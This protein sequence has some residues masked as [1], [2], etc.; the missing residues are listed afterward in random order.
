MKTR[1][2]ECVL[3]GNI[4]V[5]GNVVSHTCWDNFDLNEETPSGAGTTHSTHGI[6]IQELAVNCDVDV[7]KSAQPVESKRRSFK[8]VPAHFE[9]L[10]SSRK[11]EPCIVAKSSAAADDTYSSFWCDRGLMWVVA[12]ALFNSQGTVPD[13]SGWLSKT[14]VEECR[15]KQ[16]NIGYLLPIMQPI[17]KVATIQQCLL[18]SMEIS[19]KLKQRYTF[20][21]FDLAA[22]KIAYDVIW[23]NPHRYENVI[24]H[25]GAFHIICCYL[26]ALGRM[27][28]GSGFEEV[29]IE[30]G[31]C[32]SGSMEQVING[33]HYNRAVRVHQVMMIAV[34]QLLLEH[35]VQCTGFD[36]SLA[37]ELQALADSPTSET[38]LDAA[39]SETCREFI[40]KFRAFADSAR[41]GALGSTCQFWIQYQTCVWTLLSFLKAIKENDIPAY[42][43]LLR[44]MCP[45]ISAADRLHYARYLPMYY[46]QLS[47]LMSD[48]PEAYDLLKA[49][50][51]TVSRSSVPACCNAIDQTIEQTINRSAK[52]S[53]GII[54]FSRNVNAYYRWCLTRHKRA[55]FVEATK[56]RVGMSYNSAEVNSSCRNAELKHIQKDVRKVCEAFHNF[57]NP[58]TC[59]SSEAD[60]QLFCLSTGQPA[61]E[62]ISDSL[63]SYTARGEAATQV[64]IND[65][66]I[67]KSTKF[68]GTMKK[69]RLKTFADMSVHKVVKS[70]TQKSL[71]VIAERNL[72]GQLLLLCQSHKISF[73]KLFKYPLAPVP[74]SLATADGSM[75]KTDKAQL[76][77]VLCTEGFET[78][79]E[80]C[81]YVVDG[82]ALLYTILSVPATVGDFA[83]TVFNCLPKATVVHFVTD[84]Y[85][86]HSVKEIERQ[87]RGA[88]ATYLIGGP[89]TKMPRDF[90]SFMKNSDNKRQLLKFILCEW[91]Q[92]EYAGK[93]FGR[94]VLFVSED[95]CV[96]LRRVDG[97]SITV[98]EIAALHSTQEEADTRIVFHCIYAAEHHMSETT[99]SIVVKSPDTD[100]FV[101]LLSHATKIDASIIFE[102]G[103][104]N[105]HRLISVNKIAKA[106]GNNLAEAL[107]ALHAFTVRVPLCRNG[108]TAAD[109]IEK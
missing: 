10:P 79:P 103:T 12:H 98:T 53:G 105:N 83:R 97:T 109:D 102:T 91:C 90:A 85:M 45:L 6:V 94:T 65:R 84:S 33:K 14:A 89:S 72:L 108:I 3:P 60:H 88:S 21:T 27:M 51:L 22:A 99:K 64:F 96:E 40:D 87:R 28:V 9:L 106:I 43:S 20:V 67:T 75:C 46:T 86:K 5:T 58:V 78:Q 34:D 35:F 19:R 30:S 74:W 54:G 29:V 63:L 107:P 31:I 42:M 24:V 23:D 69:L 66:L 41:Q 36:V 104:G 71:K 57:L 16:S 100:V 93:L 15:S 61:T 25:L 13:W 37:S 56:Q 47:L 2:S 7:R 80:S 17:T 81:V 39:E 8:Y 77:H 95:S 62:D 52:T 11:V 50:S 38:L 68:H 32:S 1:W 44:Q 59:S 101:I 92:P 4:S 18:T 48:C 76:L 26:G 73:D 82:N 70:S 55:Q 49:N